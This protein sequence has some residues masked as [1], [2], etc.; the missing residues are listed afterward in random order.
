ML[1]LLASDDIVSLQT[2]NQITPLPIGRLAEFAERLEIRAELMPGSKPFS[3]VKLQQAERVMIA[4][5]TPDNL[6]VFAWKELGGLISRS[7][8]R[9]HFY[10][11]A[12][13]FSPIELRPL[14]VGLLGG[15]YKYKGFKAK[16]NEEEA[17][18]LEFIANQSQ[19]DELAELIER[20]SVV[21]EFHN[22]SRDLANTP[23]NKLNPDDMA[24]LAQE[25]C[26][27]LG[28][29]VDVWKEDRLASERCGALMSVGQGSATPPRLVRIRYGTG[30]VQLSLVGKGITFD[31]G[32]LSL[33]PADSMLGMKYDMT[34]AAVAL[35]AI[36][37]IAKL[38]L[39]IT[40]EAI[41]CLAEN[42]PGPN[43][44]RPGDVITSRNG[45]TIEVTNTDAE[46]RLVLADGIDVALEANPE[47][48][49]DI[50][51]LTGAATVALGSRYAGLFGTGQTPDAFLAAASQ[52]GERFWRMPLA[53]DSKK[54]LESSVADL[55][56][57]KVG[58]RAGGML[59]GAQFIAEFASPNKTQNWVHL[60]IANVASN[61]GA[62]YEEN[63]AGP[64]GYSLRSIVQLAENLAA[65]A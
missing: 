40:V 36:L 24:V 61:D 53:E 39:P 3:L 13:E 11:D 41:L 60:D 25:R 15:S 62:P 48:L 44:T 7:I 2:R 50:A 6:D 19:V 26:A 1:K 35:G 5:T 57:A 45:L 10:F 18:S 38:K 52:S 56:N 4:I 63:P 9:G 8:A 29:Q 49:I 28:L 37:A 64:T 59:V 31:T 51:T 32:G 33:K 27:P 14:M 58:S 43:A 12:R 17:F 55:M 46:G 23:A 42:M 47:H 21:T 16:S 65:T 54:L 22:F 34:G 30:N 20:V